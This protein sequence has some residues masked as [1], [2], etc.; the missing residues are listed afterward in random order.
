[1]VPAANLADCA[2][3]KSEPDDGLSA[4]DRESFDRLRAQAGRTAD[5]AEKL[6]LLDAAARLADM[7]VELLPSN[8][9]PETRREAA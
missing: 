9:N 6:R 3:F 4:A 2:P 7:V 8:G 5:V 1:M